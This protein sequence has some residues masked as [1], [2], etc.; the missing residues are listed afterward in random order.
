[1]DTGAQN[2]IWAHQLIDALISQGVD[3][4]CCAPG[5]RCTPLA[6][7]VANHPKA[8]RVVHFD[9]RGLCFHAV[10]YGKAAKKP[11]AIIASS[12]T[13]I[14]NFMP[15][16]MEACNERVP[17]IL[18]SSDR[19]PELRDCGANQTCDQVKLFHNFVRWQVD[20]PCPDHRIS[21]RYLASTMNHAMAMATYPPAGPVHINC[22]FREPLFSHSVSRQPLEHRVA[23]EH[24][25]LHPSDK[26]VRN[27]REI[28]STK[29]R[30]VILAGSSSTD[31][32][33][34]VF[35]LA[36]QL[37]WPIFADV[38]SSLRTKEGPPS[39]ITHF[40]PI[41][42]V[43][44]EINADAVIQFGDRFVS[45]TLA[46]WLEK[47][48]LEFYLHVSDHPM[49]QDP[50]HLITHRVQSCPNIFIQAV[51]SS[52]SPEEDWQMQWHEWDES[53]RQTLEQFF[54]SNDTVSEPGIVWEIG[55][56]LSEAWCLFVGTSMPVRDANQFLLPISGCGT[57]YGNRGVSGIDGIIATACGIAKGRDQ[58][59]L[60]L[61]G[62]LTCLHDLTSLALAAKSKQPI[63][64]C[65]VNNGGGGIFSF[66]PVSQRKE[67][68]EEFIAASHEISFAPAA[69]LFDIPYFH[70]KTVE[71]LRT[72]FLGQ[73]YH[74]YSCIIE[75]TTDR[76]E[77]VRLHEQIISKL[78]KCL[79]SANALEAAP[80]TLH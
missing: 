74:P 48:S 44:P 36:E 49:R 10:G 63:V 47:Q 53:C 52:S 22:M 8:S 71:E 14:G 12:G 6:L 79:N 13:A 15:A 39:L 75:I 46:Q 59:I 56:F 2:E 4:F 80:I 50:S 51:L 73:K 11:A 5:S 60:A 78:S 41:L 69:A 26:A 68:F 72:L 23:F 40:D 1:M 38:L 21:S 77:N 30:G 33:E 64:L 43:N 17:L 66:L 65:V 16:V 54:S 9:E 37:K 58:P 31:I 35:A 62:D 19:P 18:L 76:Q 20:L 70:P 28:L 45:K 24:A 42:K 57:I 34:S 25:V 32:S 67:A 55:S 29:R 3:Y 61:I 7:A 27:W